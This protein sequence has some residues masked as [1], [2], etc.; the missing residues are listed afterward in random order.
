VTA[1][2]DHPQ[3]AV[4]LCRSGF[5]RS[6]RHRAR[7]WRHDNSGVWMTLGNSP[8]DLILIVAAVGSVVAQI[9]APGA[10]TPTHLTSFDADGDR[11]S[12]PQHAVQDMRGYLKTVLDR[13]VY[14]GALLD[15]DAN[16]I[17]STLIIDVADQAD[18]DAFA[19]NDPFVEAGLFAETSVYPFR[20]VFKDGTWL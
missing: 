11:A 12:Q 15:G 6:A 16:Q 4:A 5:G 20:L 8:G 19:N 10:A 14:G 17:G 7:P 2:G 1:I 3:M 18:A 9:S 13:I